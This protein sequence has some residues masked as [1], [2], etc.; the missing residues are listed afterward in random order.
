MNKLWFIPLA[1]FALL[2]GLAAYRL[3]QPRDDFVRSAM[4]DQQ[5]PQFDLPP[6]TKDVEGLS[7][8]DFRDGK[9]RLLNLWASW[10]PPCVA[11]APQLETLAEQGVPIVGIA[12]RDTPENVA[13]FL[14]EHGNPY[15]RIGSDDYSAVQL[16]LGS[17]GL[18]ETFV[19]DGEGIIRYQHIGDIR[20]RD[21]PVLLR[22][23]ERAAR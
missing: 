13:R 1:A 12:F 2:A 16:A 20:E 22:E 19:I 14:A 11:E 5:L 15:Q 10:C 3:T 7:S 17:S 23:L 21:I 6:A 4:I 18:P 8:R 9:P